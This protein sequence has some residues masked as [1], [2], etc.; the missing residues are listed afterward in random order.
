MLRE[1]R[2]VLSEPRPTRE[3]CAKVE[4]RI[5]VRVCEIRVWQ[6]RVP[7]GTAPDPGRKDSR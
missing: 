6:Q 4:R 1:N 2:I 3:S 5:I 7:L